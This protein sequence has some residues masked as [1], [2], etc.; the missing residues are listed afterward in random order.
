MHKQFLLFCLR[1][2]G[3][4]YANDFPSYVAKLGLIKLQTLEHRRAVLGVCFVFNLFKG[5][6]FSILARFSWHYRPFFR[7]L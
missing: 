7:F 2:L 5:D 6:I 4:D 3:W 1:V